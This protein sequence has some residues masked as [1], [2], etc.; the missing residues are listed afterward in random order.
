M[1]AKVI[2]AAFEKRHVGGQPAGA[3]QNRNVL[4]AEL[5]LQGLACGA[6]DNAATGDQG[7][8]QVRKGLARAGAGFGQEFAAVF[9][10]VGHGKRKFDLRRARHKAARGPRQGPVGG[11]GRAHALLVID[12]KRRAVAYRHLPEL[13]LRENRLMFEAFARKFGQRNHRQTEGLGQMR[14]LIEIGLVKALVGKHAAGD[15]VEL[16]VGAPAFKT[17]FH[18]LEASLF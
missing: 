1:A 3:H 13:G 7:G 8:R 6:H 15:F 11:K 4:A 5:L 2:G 16:V 10:G 9:E 18:F 17:R 12:G 14:H